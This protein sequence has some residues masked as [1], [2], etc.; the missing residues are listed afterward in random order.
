MLLKVSV[1]SEETTQFDA[2]EAVRIGKGGIGS[3]KT[4]GMINMVK[5]RCSISQCRAKFMKDSLELFIGNHIRVVVP[6]HDSN[7]CELRRRSGGRL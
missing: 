7:R 4:Q 1:I 6:W 5:V 3:P 2:A